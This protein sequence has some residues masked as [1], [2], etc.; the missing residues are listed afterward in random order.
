MRGQ[1]GTCWP[2][3]PWRWLVNSEM[4]HGAMGRDINSI[5]YRPALVRCDFPGGS[6]GKASACNA[7]YPGS[8]PGSGRSPGEGNG[9]P[10]QYSRLENSMDGGAWWATVHGVAK[11][12]TQLSDFT[13]T[14]TLVRC[15]PSETS[16]VQW[17]YN[18]RPNRSHV[19]R[20]TFSF[21]FS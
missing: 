19:C 18:V 6:D 13:F 12:Q 15:H 3:C 8:I 5:Y 9:S 14:F 17:K 7:G 10:L 21:F 4:G 20:F 11:S 16:T 2:A 1:L